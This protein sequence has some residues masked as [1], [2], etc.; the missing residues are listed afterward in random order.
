MTRRAARRPRADYPPIS[1]G[2]WR[3][4]S[5]PV[6]LIL[7]AL[8]VA[9]ERRDDLCES[10]AAGAVLLA[11]HVDGWPRPPCDVAQYSKTSHERLCAAAR[12]IRIELDLDVPPVRTELVQAVLD[13]LNDDLLDGNAYLRLGVVGRHLL[14]LADETGIAPGTSRLTV[15]AS[16]VYAADRLTDEK[17]LI[18]QQVV[19]AG[20]SIVETSVSKL[21]RYSREL[22]DAYVDRHA[23]DDPSVV[24]DRDDVRV[25]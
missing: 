9:F 23:T 7:P 3:P 10:L 12:K 24:L 8:D 14:E 1:C 19:D 11:A 22:H 2:R 20:S 18:Q 25:V 17:W 21:G 6:V 4:G 13:A 15:A 16:A 5:Q